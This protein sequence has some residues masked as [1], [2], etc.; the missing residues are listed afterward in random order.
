[1]RTLEITLIEWPNGREAGGPRLLG[2]TTDPNLV[3]RV[4]ENLA[5]AQ[6]RWLAH[7]EDSSVRLVLDDEE[8][9]P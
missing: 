4:Q 8:P 7:L 5:S 3:N 2:R 9:A 6:R 1:V